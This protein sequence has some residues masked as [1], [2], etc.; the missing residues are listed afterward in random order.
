MTHKTYFPNE[1]SF[2]QEEISRIFLH[3]SL[4]KGFWKKFDESH[5]KLM[6][7]VSVKADPLTVM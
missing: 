7:N 1:S 6:A 4:Y 5:A 3:Q 2:K